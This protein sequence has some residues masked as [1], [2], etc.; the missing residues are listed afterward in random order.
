MPLRNPDKARE[1]P[2]AD[3]WGECQKHVNEMYW[4]DRDC[5]GPPPAKDTM[6]RGVVV[7]GAVIGRKGG[8]AGELVLRTGGA[9][10]FDDKQPEVA[11]ALAEQLREVADALDR[12]AGS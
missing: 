11:Q 12:E 2:G 7:V 5:Y 9:W 8:F 10:T 6:F 3:P 1:V 4:G